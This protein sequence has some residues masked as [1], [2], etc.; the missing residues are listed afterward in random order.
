M[1]YFH[2]LLVVPGS[3]AWWFS[4]SLYRLL[5]PVEQIKL[6]DRLNEK[7]HQQPKKAKGSS[8]LLGVDILFNPLFS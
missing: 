3:A 2:L 6:S 1:E 5:F 7:Q 8:R 4:K